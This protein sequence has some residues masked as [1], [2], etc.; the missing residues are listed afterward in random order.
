MHSEEMNSGIYKIENT[1]NNKIYIGSAINFKNREWH[2]FSELKFNKHHSIH[3]QRSYNKYNKENFEFIRLMDCPIDELLM[4]EQIF[5][6]A[7][8]PEY[9][10]CKIAA[11]RLGHKCNNSTKEKM[12]QAN[13]GKKIPEKTLNKIRKGVVQLDKNN[14]VINI[15][16][17][18]K[19][20]SNT[21]N[22]NRSD[23]CSCCRYEAGSIKEVRK[24]AGGYRFMFK[25]QYELMIKES[26]YE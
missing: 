13:L 19:I 23:I 21:L 20:A 25:K 26:T 5:I 22:I 15:F 1:I 10:I 7:F 6:N 14:N 9:N 17:D 18:S 24:T 8:N 12:R 11:S 4:T 16:K 2:H 3:L